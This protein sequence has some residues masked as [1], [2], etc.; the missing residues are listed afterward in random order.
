MWS[1]DFTYMLPK[2][3]QEFGAHNCQNYM[4]APT[5]VHGTHCTNSSRRLELRGVWVNS[6]IEKVS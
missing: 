4:L 3:I 1:L 6:F 2:L 5:I